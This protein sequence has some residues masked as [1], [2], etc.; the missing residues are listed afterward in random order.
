MA[1]SKFLPFQ[2]ANGDNMPDA[3]PELEPA[4]D[5]CL[6]CSPNPL[7]VVPNWRKRTQ[8]TPF[9]NEK[10]CKYQVTY[11]TQADKM[12]GGLDP[13]ASEAQQA[14]EA[15]AGLQGL[16]EKYADPWFDNVDKERQGAIKRILTVNNKEISDETM[17]I[18]REN[19]EYSDFY[20]DPRPHS[21]LKL[22]YS[23]DFDVIEDLPDAL[24]EE[25]PE[26]PSD[27]V[28]KYEAHDLVIKSIRVRKGL[29]L[30][31]RYYTMYRAL[32]KSNLLFDD[33]KIFD[34]EPYG[35]D[36][37]FGT[38]ALL[39][40]V[41]SELDAWLNVKGYNIPNVG[42][43]ISFF[44]D[45]IK[46]LEFTFDPEYNLKKLKVWTVDCGEYP[47]SWSKGYLEDLKS[48]RAWKDKT[49]VAYFAQLNELE[50]KMNA[51]VEQPWIEVITEYTYPR[52]HPALHAGHRNI[53][54]T[55]DV[56]G[57]IADALT[58]EMKALGQDILDDV[59]SIG[60]A[61]AYLFH[62]NLCRHDPTEVTADN[63]SIGKVFGIPETDDGTNIWGAA[64]MQA[65]KEIDPR[66]QIFAHFCLYFLTSPGIGEG[67]P[68]M[69]PPGSPM[70]ML[71][72]L[73][74]GS[75]DRIAMCGLFDLLGQV[76]EC[77]L[78]GLTLEE[79]LKKML[80]S[81][82]KAM[83]WDDFSSL[84][85]GLPPDKQ[86]EL[87]QLVKKNLES[88]KMVDSMFNTTEY[89]SE[90]GTEEDAGQTPFFGGWEVVRP[91]ENEKLVD[92]QKQNLRSNSASGA[93]VATKAPSHKSSDETVT[94]RT[95][96]QKY[97]VASTQDAMGG[98]DPNVVMDAYI[99]ALLE[100]FE[101]NL[102]GLLDEMNNFPGAEI[103]SMMIT[104]IDCPTP[105][106]FNPGVMDFIKSITLPFC[107]TKAP[108]VLPRWENPLI[109]IPKFKDIFRVLWE[110]AKMLLRQLIIKIIVRILVK[111][112]ELIGDAICKALELVGNMAGSLPAMVSGR[113]KFSDVV[114]DSICGPD[115]DDEE[116][117]NVI[118]QLM[119]D[120]GVGGQAL[121]NPDR[122]LTYM[123][124]LSAAVTQQEMMDA[125]LG[126]ASPEFKT[127]ADEI[128]E[129]E[130]PEYNDALP[131]GDAVAS[132]FKNVGRL[133]PVQFRSELQDMARTPLTDNLPANPTLCA[134]PEGIEE[135]KNLRC[136]L[137]E[138]RASAEQCE[139]MFEKWRGTLL[140]DLG[141]I[142]DIANKGLGNYVAEQMP[143]IFSDPGCDNGLLPYEPEQ[144]IAAAT[145]G[146][147]DDM[148]KLKV[149]FSSDMLENGPGRKK[150]GLINMVMS[151]TLGNPYTAHQR[152]TFNKK[153]YVDFYMDDDPG[154]MFDE[155]LEEALGQNISV[156]R[157]QKGAYPI[158]VAD[159]L[160][161]Q[162]QKAGD[163]FETP[164]A[165]AATYAVNDLKDSLN[166]ESN[167]K[168]QDD[169]Y[170][171]RSFDRMSIKAGDVDI[172][173]MPSPGYN[174]DVIPHLDDDWEGGGYV[175]FVKNL[176]KGQPD[177]KLSFKDNASGLRH[178]P[179]GGQSE[180]GYGF[181][182]GCYFSDLYRDDGEYV[183]APP[184]DD[185]DG[186][187]VEQWVDGAIKNYPGDNMRIY[188]S[189]IL[190]QESK[191][192]DDKAGLL[193][194]DPSDNPNKRENKETS[195][196][197]FRKYEFLTSDDSLDGIDLQNYPTLAESFERHVP[198]SPPVL[199]LYD[200]LGGA[201][202]RDAAEY[203]YNKFMSN[204]FKKVAAEIG[205]NESVW[206]YGAKYDN[207]SFA[208]FEYVVPKSAASLMKGRGG[209]G[210]PISS[211]DVLV[212]DYNSKGEPIGDGRMINNDDAILG[213]SLSQ[214]LAEEDGDPGKAR[215]IYLDPGKYGGTYM[216]PPVYVKPITGSG[217]M[218][219]VD[220]MFPELSPCKP[221]RTDLVDF[222]EVQDK[223]DQLYPKLTSD[224]RL[225]SDPDC[226][227]EVPYARVLDRPAKAGLMGAITAAIKMFV[228]VH[229]LKGLPTFATYAPKFPD[230][231]SN[232]YA[233]YII[234]RMEEQFKDAGT[235][236]FSPFQDYEFWYAFL[237]QSVQLY[238]LRIGEDGDI[239]EEDVPE[240]VR[241]AL[242][243]LDDLQDEYNYPSKE[244]KAKDPHTPWYETLE[245]Y[246]ESKNLEA[247][248][249]SQDDAKLILKQL[250][251]EELRLTGEKFTENLRPLGFDIVAQDL[252]YYY[253][254]AF[255]AGSTL[256]LDGKLAEKPVGLPTPEEPD[257]ATL[258]WSW[259]GPFYSEG[260][261]FTTTDDTKYV[262]YYHAHID[263]QDGS[264]VYMQGDDMSMEFTS[265]DAMDDENKKTLLRPFANKTIMGLTSSSGFV[266]IGDVPSITDP[267]TTDD[268]YPFIIQK[269]IRIE[270]SMED[271]AA[272]VAKVHAKGT[273]NI[274]DHFPGTMTLVYPLPDD[275][276]QTNRSEEKT[277]DSAAKLKLKSGVMAG[278]TRNKEM[279]DVNPITGEIEDRSKGP[280]GVVGE[281]GV[282]YG[283]VFSIDI[284]GLREITRVEVDAL[285]IP[286]GSFNGLEK[287]S[288]MLLCLLDK[289]KEDEKYR[290]V[291]NY[292]FSLKKILGITAIYN[293]M[294]FLPSI[295]EW[296]VGPGHLHRVTGLGGA[297]PASGAEGLKPGQYAYMT[298]DSVE[299]DGEDI[300]FVKD[301]KLEHGAPGWATRATRVEGY[302][303]DNAFFL[304]YHEWDQQ[305]LR[306]SC[307]ILRK[308]FRIYYH[309]RKFDAGEDENGARQW[310]EQLRERFRISPGARFLPWWK[311]NKLRGNPYNSD[312]ELC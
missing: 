3:C 295:G 260:N 300:S 213:V 120:L 17:Q 251:I 149:A 218:G 227:V 257:P 210:W 160:M 153:D 243:R 107:R 266:G 130:Y 143:P 49:A 47:Q 74:D 256:Q 84:F 6:K 226:I 189:E 306:R 279:Y 171:K 57:C 280:V 303:W 136:Q 191:V 157:D 4:Q 115:A 214:F 93:M 290:L 28:V 269:Y 267:V 281:L 246:R 133:M 253:M 124:D 185:P 103:I 168:T 182:I 7:A 106:L 277:P 140:D 164:M 62:K 235:A 196:L 12:A 258:G 71:D 247:V 274:S 302:Q 236:L 249:N 69:G 117:N 232:I 34:L 209:P 289:L 70:Q 75:L 108:I 83:A 238:G 41:V 127:I 82:L 43:S 126:Q 67:C 188:I 203:H 287:D 122:A 161:Y 239:P 30:Y 242:N 223:I 217:W 167:N 297:W 98:L 139:E 310:L 231:Y 24:P 264:V 259:P 132:F 224:T 142:A 114:K 150:W 272:A 2:D 186:E 293:D 79:A 138:G 137:L 262:G 222:N 5:I 311:R 294:A 211:P 252:D 212:Q 95:L 77:I 301:V 165:P 145:R 88:G 48:R 286:V 201:V 273:G 309:S 230:N 66:D 207:L 151:D 176:R 216:N 158:Y 19:L 175:A 32:E 245:S 147:K 162:F 254:S 125:V 155:E 100:L 288:K 73:W 265:V 11:R 123:E 184:A 197:K 23:V 42:S 307:V 116:V 118:T 221:S 204:H 190:N 198:N 13:N 50:G 89:T 112:C 85:A 183:S 234:E 166:F 219:I 156:Y 25:E 180:Y 18:V 173:A 46:E 248:F 187:P 215:V 44:K 72:D 76:I 109:W 87:D 275:M 94:R 129:N 26:D 154:G 144:N 200:L 177:I 91:F 68:P 199:A 278:G 52:V 299:V 90:A 179:N 304:Q 312:G 96:A 63:V 20:L 16:F 22:L 241:A 56:P 178:G 305:T 146:L 159:Y 276:M 92:Q 65:H 61:I 60:D 194:E 229:F 308:L 27:I 283:L 141:D 270:N 9:L 244:D 268:Q 113:K 284:G 292:I 135:F 148:D 181:S 131:N 58:N 10:L 169:A 21:Y 170:Y 255:C 38:D 225:K 193:P 110:V 296:T 205:K 233:A 54:A 8:K 104:T 111:I 291:T 105:P 261:E 45:K 101:D 121:R 208:D 99:M 81:A 134:T 250:V 128:R 1:D 172:I 228:S 33:G 174:V 37:L 15:S 80:L 202:T 152:K 14:I 298:F 29:N 55:Q 97:A 36:A 59:F 240:D 51:R 31:S 195:E 282:R 39:A 40:S 263:E 206:L 102:L 237:E 285:D 35:D 53:E 163:T 192:Y 78:G 220:I 86:W 64:V 119:S 271:P